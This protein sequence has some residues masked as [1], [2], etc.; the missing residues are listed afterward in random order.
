VINS[1]AL[2]EV[3]TA[4]N[5][6]ND[7]LLSGGYEAPFFD[8]DVYRSDPLPYFA[9]QSWVVSARNSTDLETHTPRPGTLTASALCYRVD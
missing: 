3:V 8:M 6:N 5:D 9:V 1:G 4:C 2:G 7:I